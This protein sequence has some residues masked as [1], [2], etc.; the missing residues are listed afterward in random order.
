M[1]RERLLHVRLAEREPGLLH[2]LRVGA[3]D[4]DVLG[5]ER[6]AGRQAGE[7]VALDL[8]A[9]EAAQ[10]ILGERLD[11]LHSGDRAGAAHVEVVQE[12][13]W[14]FGAAA[15]VV[16]LVEDFEPHV[17]EDREA[18]RE[19]QRA[20]EPVDAQAQRPVIAFN[21]AVEA[22]GERLLV[23]QALDELQVAYRHARRYLVAVTDRE[24]GSIGAV[25]GDGLL[26]AH[27]L[28]Q[29]VLEVVLPAPRGL[30][31]VG[32]DRADVVSAG[33][34]GKR[35]NQHVDARERRI[36]KLHRE[37][38]ARAVQVALQD[39]LDLQ[40][41]LGVVVLARQVDEARVETAIDIAANEDAGPAPVAEP[42]DAERRFVEGLDVD[43]EELVARIELQHREQRLVRVA[44]GAEGR[45]IDEGG[46]LAAQERYVAR[47]GMVCRGGVEADEAALADHL[48][49]GI[50]SLDADVVEVSGPVH[51]RARIRL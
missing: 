16:R 4:I 28:D 41:H 30:R 51:G 20:P 45:A 9:R 7:T 25:Q 13:G 3:N 10:R 39:L 43:V 17:L 33:L 44:V 5:A 18:S 36:G 46:H 1:R 24:R 31:D 34:F 21:R 26:L 47:V 29:R 40:A 42:Q 32:L 22:H 8:A 15:L 37:F 27:L 12:Y 49:R 2:V 19:R 35:A 23:G 14:G 6:G 11:R 38:H 50:E 48:A